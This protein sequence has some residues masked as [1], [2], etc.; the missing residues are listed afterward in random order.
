MRSLPPLRV[1]HDDL[2]ARELEVEDAK[3]QALHEAKPGAVHE[4]RHQ[5]LV[6]I[7]LTED[8]LHLIA[9]E[10][11]RQALG[12][13]G[14][15]EVGELPDLA[16]DDVT[17][18]EQECGESLSLRRGAH[19]FIDGQ[20][21]EECVDLGLGHVGWM[22]DAVEADEAPDPEAVGLLSAPAVVARAQSGMHLG[23]ELGHGGSRTGDPSVKGAA[24]SSMGDGERHPRST[25]AVEALRPPPEA[26][27]SARRTPRAGGRSA[28]DAAG[29]RARA[30]AGRTS[31][32][33]APGSPAPAGRGARRGRRPRG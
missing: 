19:L 30:R 18:E 32:S 31:C 10:H 17:V 11:H 33:R 6:A 21:S 24:G 27:T 26:A 25:R 5:P 9:R 29:S 13:A 2:A 7:E 3:A 23:H 22:T 14:A 1:T 15:D 16:A 12:L 4:R 28:P 20:V 8:G